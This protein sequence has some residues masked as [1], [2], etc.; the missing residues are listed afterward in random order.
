M[1]KQLHYYSNWAA[2]FHPYIFII[3]T[4][5]K[6]ILS[7]CKAGHVIFHLQSLWSVSQ[8]NEIQSQPSPPWIP[9]MLCDLIHRMLSWSNSWP[10]SH[11]LTSSFTDLLSVSQI[12]LFSAL[13]PFHWRHPQSGW[14]NNHT[15]PSM[16]SSQCLLL[17]HLPRVAF[18]I[19]LWEPVSTE[20]SYQSFSTILICSIFSIDLI[21]GAFYIY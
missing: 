1:I 8:Q 18:F 3:P 4:A 19:V 6:V 7:G 17:S 16:I 21:I 9:K 14:P 20:K 2:C 13:G 12:W 5:F 10:F 15:R 11:L